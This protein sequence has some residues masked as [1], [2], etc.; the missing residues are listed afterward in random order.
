MLSEDYV[1]QCPFYFIKVLIA[2]KR[3]YMLVQLTLYSCKI[4]ACIKSPKL[5]REHNL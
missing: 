5:Q 4:T 1:F 3:S 2:E